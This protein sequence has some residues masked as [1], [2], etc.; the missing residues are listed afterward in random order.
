MIVKPDEA[1]TMTPGGIALA[2]S[3]QDKP[4]KGT[5]VMVAVDNEP[6]ILKGCQVLYQKHAGSVVEQD[7]VEYLILNYDEVLAMRVPNKE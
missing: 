6:G 5:V 1:V 3:A 2:E 4:T 7:G